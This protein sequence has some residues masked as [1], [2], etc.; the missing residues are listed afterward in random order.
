M[1]R[2]MDTHHQHDVL[3]IGTGAAGLS[4]A[5]FLLRPRFLKAGAAEA[6]AL[7]SEE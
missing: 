1:Q 3:I 2:F 7:T 5:Y 6:R 4:L